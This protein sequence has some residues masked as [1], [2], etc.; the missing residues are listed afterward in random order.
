M[1]YVL[2][3]GA[4][5]ASLLLLGI[6]LF[7]CFFFAFL[8]CLSFL[9]SLPFPSLPSPPLPFPPLPF[10]SLPRYD[11]ILYKFNASRRLLAGVQWQTRGT[12][13]PTPYGECEVVNFR[14]RDHTLVLKPLWRHP[15]KLARIYMPI[16]SVVTAEE[17]SVQT[18]HIHM[19]EEDALAQSVRYVE[20][21][22]AERELALM[23]VEDAAMRN[24][25]RYYNSVEAE[26]TDLA[27]AVQRA[28]DRA[29]EETKQDRLQAEFLHK[30]ELQVED[31]AARMMRAYVQFVSTGSNKR[32][33]KLGWYGA[34]KL[35]KYLTRKAKEDYVLAE[36]AAAKKEVKKKWVA[37]RDEYVVADTLEEVFAELLGVMVEEVAAESHM[38]GLSAKERGEEE[39]GFVMAEP[40]VQYV[41]YRS[42]FFLWNERK[43]ALKERVSGFGGAAPCVVVQC[44]AVQCCSAAARW[45]CVM[46]VHVH[47][48][49]P[50][51]SWVLAVCVR[52][53]P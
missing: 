8:V 30:A 40:H 24:L 33:K 10:P 50:F 4:V 15:I 7:L 38:E 34:F 12:R 20:R 32:P 48:V 36:V 49:C 46:C 13:I 26:A 35:K 2:G 9:P 19:L 21:T 51:V 23:R 17:A 42:V 27:E 14:T 25:R 5:V 6:V 28:A 43:A 11:K 39:A 52:V 18:E 37:T 41:V 16:D 45:H 31:T 29:L 44:S 47:C 1:L 53:S 3:V 22:T